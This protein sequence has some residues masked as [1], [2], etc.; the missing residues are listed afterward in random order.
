M[1]GYWGL[2]GWLV[3]GLLGYLGCLS[4]GHCCIHA[5]MNELLLFLFFTW[6]F[7]GWL[8]LALALVS[9]ALPGYLP[10]IHLSVHPFFYYAD[11]QTTH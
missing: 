1:G 3:V 7:L 10:I 9:V 2:A 5:C 11:R 6:S 4:L 8:A